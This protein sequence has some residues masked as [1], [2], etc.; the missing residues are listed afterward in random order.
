MKIKKIIFEYE[1][2]TQKYIDGEDINLWNS[3]IKYL[4]DLAYSQGSIIDW[5]LLNWKTEK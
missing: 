1:D 3:W 4:I 2:G 5:K